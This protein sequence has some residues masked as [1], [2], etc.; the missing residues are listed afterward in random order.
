MAQQA[1]THQ[2][3]DKL[4][5]DMPSNTSKNSLRIPDGL[6]LEKS[7][8]R[9]GWGILDRIALLRITRRERH[10]ELNDSYKELLFQWR[11]RETCIS[12]KIEGSPSSLG[13]KWTYN[14]STSGFEMT[15]KKT[16]KRTMSALSASRS[17]SNTCLGRPG[18]HG[19]L[20]GIA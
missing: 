3:R 12:R 15:Q 14:Q 18:F 17:Q 6:L 1:P 16:A 2:C 19:I 8:S 7:L 5:R 9:A 4:G 13:R 11:A 10:P 20:K